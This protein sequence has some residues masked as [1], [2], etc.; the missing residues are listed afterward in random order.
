MLFK[1]IKRTV[2]TP[3][4]AEEMIQKRLEQLSQYY[5][6]FQDYVNSLIAYDCWAEK[7]HALT[8]QAFSPGCRK[9]ELPKLWTEIIRDFGKPDKTGS[10]F[11][12]RAEEFV[13][14]L[15]SQPTKTTDDPTV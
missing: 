5:E 13:Q 6:S 4:E 14:E 7:D 10:Y 15:K 12:H 9:T 2:S 8:G 1:K 3:G 11:A